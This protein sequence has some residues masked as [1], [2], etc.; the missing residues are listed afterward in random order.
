MSTGEEFKIKLEEFISKSPLIELEDIEVLTYERN[1]LSEECGF[2]APLYA[3]NIS[4]VSGYS[5]I[6]NNIFLTITDGEVEEIAFLIRELEKLEGADVAWGDVQKVSA[7]FFRESGIFG[8]YLGRLNQYEFFDT[9]PDVFKFN[10]DEYKIKVLLFLSKGEV[11][12]YESDL[13]E[14]YE[15]ISLKDPI[16]F[17]ARGVR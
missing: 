14:F 4:L 12:L 3:D 8:V 9:F 6:G 2:F 15:V 13:D 7:P 5:N 1:N 16:K 17:G 10:K 11:E